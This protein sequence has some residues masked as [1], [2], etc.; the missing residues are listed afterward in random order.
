MLLGERLRH[1]VVGSRLNDGVSFVAHDPGL[2]RGKWSREQHAA[3]HGR[4][5]SHAASWARDRGG[6]GTTAVCSN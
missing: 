4:N 6:I 5:S 3:D 1:R 2:L